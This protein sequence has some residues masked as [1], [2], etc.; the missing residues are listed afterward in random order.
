M[1]PYQQVFAELEKRQ[2]RYLVAGGFA[3]NFH[4][5]QRATVDLDL[6]V[7]LQTE[8]LLSF[9]SLMT[10]LGFVPRLPVRA[11]DFAD[12]KI[13]EEWITQKH[14]MVFSFVKPDN[15]FEIIDVFAR[16]PMPFDELWSR[17]FEIQAFGLKI[18]VVGKSDLIAMKQGTGREKDEFDIRQLEKSTED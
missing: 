9:V 15:P 14:M 1:T 16:E 4:Q 8:N 18:K 12:S 13:R 10:D 6:I 11:I 5:V 2:I 7:H 3:V 17:H